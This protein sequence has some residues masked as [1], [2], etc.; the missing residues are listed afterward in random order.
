MTIINMLRTLM[1][2]VE[3]ILEQMGTEMK[4]LRKKRN[5]RGQKLTKM[6]NAFDRL[7]NKIEEKNSLSLRIC[8]Q[9]LSELKS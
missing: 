7:T 5:T 1:N 6:K 9:K 4:I 8:Q 3:S 2:K